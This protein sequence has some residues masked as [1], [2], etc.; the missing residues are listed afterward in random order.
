VFELLDGT[1]HQQIYNGSTSSSSEARRNYLAQLLLA[2][3]ELHSVQVVHRDLRPKNVLVQGKRLKLCDFGMAR[4]ISLRMS[5]LQNTTTTSYCAPEGLLNHTRY[6]T[7]SDMWSLGIIMAEMIHG[8]VLFRGMS[9]ID[10]LRQIFQALGRPCDEQLRLMTTELVRV[11]H[12]SML[13]TLTH[14]LGHDLTGTRG[15][16]DVAIRDAPRLASTTCAIARVSLARSHRLGA[17]SLEAAALDR[18]RAPH[19]C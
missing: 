4:A 12:Y 5:L 3:R 17:R 19:H 10:Q 13:H 15:C 7:A 11:T 8:S 16:S 2:L 9:E 18:S 6:T 14:S 1:L